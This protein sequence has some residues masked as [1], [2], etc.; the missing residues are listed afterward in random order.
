MT[1]LLASLLL[2]G[3]LQVD[4]P[5]DEGPMGGALMALRWQLLPEATLGAQ[6]GWSLGADDTNPERLIAFHRSHALALIGLTPLG[7]DS[8]LRVEGRVGLSYLNGW[9]FGALPRRTQFSPT[10][11]AGVTAGWPIGT[12]WGHPMFIDV[13]GTYDTFRL[14]DA[15]LGA[16][17]FV[18]GLTSQLSGHEE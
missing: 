18:L 3:G 9:P 4:V 16:P 2:T 13:S 1:A 11:G 14:A 10:L 7:S 12:W 5:G 15:W 8:R 6:L 17:G